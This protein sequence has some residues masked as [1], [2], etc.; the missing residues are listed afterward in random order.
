MARSKIF[1]LAKIVFLFS[2]VRILLHNANRNEEDH[3]EGGG[4]DLQVA[5]ADAC[6]TQQGGRFIAATP[7]S[8]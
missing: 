3:E 6:R 1:T 5:L 4:H 8:A 2:K 7:G